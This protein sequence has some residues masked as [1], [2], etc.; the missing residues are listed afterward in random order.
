MSIRPNSL[1][2][3]FGMSAA[4]RTICP[5][6]SAAYCPKW[7]TWS[8]EPRAVSRTVPAHGVV[9]NSKLALVSREAYCVFLPTAGGTLV[10]KIGMGAACNCHRKGTGGSATT[11]P[12]FDVRNRLRAGSRENCSGNVGQWSFVTTALLLVI[13][14]C[15]Q[16]PTANITNPCRRIEQFPPQPVAPTV[17]RAPHSITNTCTFTL[18]QSFRSA[19]QPA[20]DQP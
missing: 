10:V 15:Q 9:Y 11:L 6:N 19:K 20:T 8:V 14:D 2:F 18:M 1:Q 12:M 17:P 13:S 7:A 4:L 5:A 16:L 3:Y